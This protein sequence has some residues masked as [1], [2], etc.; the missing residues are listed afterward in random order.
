MQRGKD[1]RPGDKVR[2]LHEKGEGLVTKL[3][4]EFVYVDI[5]EG[6]EIP[7][8]HND[9][10]IMERAQPELP[11]SEVTAPII[12]SSPKEKLR[13][14]ADIPKGIYI[15]FAPLNQKVL[16]TGDVKVYLM[17]YSKLGLM[18]T[19]FLPRDKTSSP[20]YSGSV[21]PA[22]AVLIDTVER[23]ELSR[24]SK[25]IFQSIFT[26]TISGGIPAPYSTRMEIKEGKFLKEDMYMSNPLIGMYSLTSLLLRMDEL[27]LITLGTD[28]RF[29]SKEAGEGHSKLIEDFGIIGK[30]RTAQGEAEVDL[31]I[32]KLVETPETIN[33]AAKLKLQ[34]DFC[35]ECLESAIEHSYKKVVFIHGVGVG[36]LKMEI[37]RLL[38]QYDNLEYRDAPIAKYGIG[39]TEVL[40]F[41]K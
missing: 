16:L 38:K 35:K 28:D 32:D 7:M 19:L 22:S 13:K 26:G 1:C 4:H 25:G 17:N 12:Q 20:S 2:F 41:S 14:S 30:F 34:L 36:I 40:L 37:H 15:A 33:D 6:F 11:S 39:A 29:F 18:Y 23:Q 21:E 27:N 9:V 5:G 3:T 24:F 31:H 8:L 10:I